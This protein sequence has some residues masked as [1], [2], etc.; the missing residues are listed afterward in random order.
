M[1]LSNKASR[2]QEYPSICCSLHSVPY[3]LW[4]LGKVTPQ[5][6]SFYLP[7][8]PRVLCGSSSP[9]KDFEVYIHYPKSSIMLLL[10]IYPKGLIWK[11]G[12]LPQ[13]VYI[14]F[15]STN[16]L[17]S[18]GCQSLSYRPTSGNHDTIFP[19]VQLTA[20]I[21]TCRGET[22]QHAGC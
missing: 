14:Y 19:L 11:I 2:W 7:A 5:W 17:D 20:L 22:S 21:T 18:P 12:K 9:T 13:D 10:G 15:D 4:D 1:S 8:W 6:G 3:W 16:I